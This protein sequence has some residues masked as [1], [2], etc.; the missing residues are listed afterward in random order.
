MASREIDGVS[1]TVEHKRHRDEWLKHW[2]FQCS[3]EPM[4]LRAEVTGLECARCARRI[5]RVQE[6]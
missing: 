5:V 1:P 2:R 3:C 4:E 6:T